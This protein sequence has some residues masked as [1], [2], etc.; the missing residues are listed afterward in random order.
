[1]SSDSSTTSRAVIRVHGHVQGVFFRAWAQ[2]QAEELG[3]VGH[4]R[5]TGDGE[6]EVDAQ[7]ERTAVG[8][9]LQ[10]LE[11]RPS[12]HDRPGSVDRVEVQWEEPEQGRTGFDRR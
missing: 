7:G 4:A 3:V 12:S 6:V 5:N 8:Q 9:L 1:M 11:E 10:R 2:S